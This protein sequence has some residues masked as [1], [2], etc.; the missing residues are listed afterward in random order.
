MTSMTIPDI[1]R[2]IKRLARIFPDQTAKPQY[3]SFHGPAKTPEPESIVGHALF[4]LGAP[5]SLLR[6]NNREGVTEVLS[7][8]FNDNIDWERYQ[9]AIDWME[10]V[11]AAEDQGDTWEEAVKYARKNVRLCV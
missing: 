8:L 5:M 9:T 2:E 1:K 6:Q 4:N 3:M 10:T 11:V 7:K